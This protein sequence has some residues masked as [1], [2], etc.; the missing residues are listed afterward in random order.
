MTTPD[1]HLNTATMPLELHPMT[2]ADTLSWTRVRALAYYGPTQHLLH[3]GPITE[4]SLYGMAQDRKRELLR[5]HTWHWKIVDTELEPSA[6]D[7]EGNGGRIIAISVWSMH[8]VKAGEEEEAVDDT[9]SFVPPELRL[10]ADASLKNP[11]RAARDEV[12]GTSTPFFVLNQLATHPEQQGRGA[13]K[14]MLDW[15]LRKADEESLAT[16]LN[17]TIE[18][19]RVYERRGFEVVK[20]LEWDRVPWGGEGSDWH[21]IMVRQPGVP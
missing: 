4:S 7:S 13:A 8:N 11:I 9:P 14:I 6:D 15:G 2:P 20:E 19:R 5:P 16:Y 1:C 12:M 10:D 18:G 3:S 17:A 21:S